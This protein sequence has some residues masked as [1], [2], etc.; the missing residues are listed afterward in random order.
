VTDE[1]TT[2]RRVVFCAGNDRID[3]ADVKVVR[4]TGRSTLTRHRSMLPTPGQN[5][6]HKKTNGRGLTP[7]PAQIRR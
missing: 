7:A 6:D 4:P 3:L 2:E 5:N 1:L